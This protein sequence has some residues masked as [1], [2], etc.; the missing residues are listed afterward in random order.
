MRRYV[1][2]EPALVEVPL[3]GGDVTEGVVRVGETV[4]RPPGP[5][6]AAVRAYLEHLERV[7]FDG[8]PRFLGID[9]RGR[10][11]LSF[12]PGENA[13]RP[14]HAWARDEAVLLAI[15]RLQRNLHDRSA[16]FALPAG[17]AWP[18]PACIQGVAPAY[19]VADVVGHNDMTPENLIFV[20]RRLT[21][22]VDFDLA[23][24]TTR[25]LDIVTTLLWCA[26]LRAPADRDPLLRD[27]DSVRRARLFAD[28]YGLAP[29]ERAR[30][31]EVAARRY[32]RSWHVMRY[33]AERRGGG[34]RRMWDDGVGDVILRGQA[35]FE[36]ERPRF[37]AA[38]AD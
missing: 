30:L 27:A 26:P 24:P 4:R 22:V 23:G 16:G 38:F 29:A 11:V 1:E 34:W 20:D 21:G 25:L 3:L 33:N 7:G 8:A 14:L 28:A 19:D 31:P 6:S 2:P 32:A 15:A 10:D 5:H 18:E 12:V 17:V 9:A 35:W 36:A 37:A 13:G